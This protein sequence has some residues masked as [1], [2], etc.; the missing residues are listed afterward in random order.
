MPSIRRPA[1]DLRLPPSDFRH[2]LRRHFGLQNVVAEIGK[3]AESGV[4]SHQFEIYSEG[5]RCE[6]GVLPALRL[7]P[8]CGAEKAELRFKTHR[9]INEAHSPVR[10][11]RI[12]CFPNLNPPLHIRSHHHGIIE[13]TKHTE[14]ADPAEDV[15]PS[16]WTASNQATDAAW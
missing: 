14:L 3:G 5:K 7:A 4:E 6:V 15:S 13:K 16:C 2:L 11:Q 10:Q 8:K 9:L 12:P 1:S